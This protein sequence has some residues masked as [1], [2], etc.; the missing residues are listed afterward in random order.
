MR[1]RIALGSGS[2]SLK[3]PSP[4][5]AP[6]MTIAMTAN[7]RSTPLAAQATNAARHAKAAKNKAISTRMA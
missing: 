7:S 1:A 4:A 2:S 6:H 3:T 5:M